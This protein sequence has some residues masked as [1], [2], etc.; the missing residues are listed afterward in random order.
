MNRNKIFRTLTAAL[1]LALLVLA[2]PAT[3]A[4]AQAI[5]CSP[6]SGTVGTTVAIS[7]QNL[8]YIGA[9]ATVFIFFN[10][11]YAGSGTITSGTA[12]P[13][14]N[15]VISGSFAVPATATAGVAI[16]TVWSLPA[17]GGVGNTQLGL[18]SFTV[19]VAGITISPVQG[20]VGDTVIISGTGF[21]P[22]TVVTI[23]FDAV[24][25]T[26]SPASVT[27]TTVGSFTNVTF[28][29][30]A[31]VRGSHIVRAQDAALNSATATFTTLPKVTLTPAT[32]GVG[33]TPL[34]SGTGFAAGSAVTF[35]MDDVLI[36]GATATT[37]TTGSFTNTPVTIPAGYRG[38]HPLKAQDAS[39]NVAIATFTI[40]QKITITPTTGSAG[41]TVTVAGTGFD[42]SKGITITYGGTSVTTTPAAVNTGATGSFSGVTFNVPAGV[43]TTYSVV[44]SDGIYSASA[45]FVATASA[46]ISQ[47]T[48]ATSPG[49]VGM[50]LVISGTGFKASPATVT[51]T[52]A[53]DPVTLATV[54][55]DANGSFSATVTI[56]ASEGGQHT[57]TVSDGTT[58][59][60]FTFFMEE[61][62][63]PV[64][65]PLLPLMDSKAKQPVTFDWQDVTDD[66]LPVTYTL[67]IARDTA[68]TDIVLEKPGLTTSGYTLTE[69]EKLE[70]VSKDEPYLW[71]VK[72]I[73]AASNESAWTG[74]GSFYVGFTLP[75]LSDLPDWAMYTIYGV[76]GLLL[77]LIGFWVGRR[78]MAY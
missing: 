29:V 53:T 46:T 16:I 57:I 44:A 3:P 77:F 43:A 47:T 2:V 37:G 51:I 49:H 1:I 66:S 70:S 11:N 6:T 69:A 35:Y 42:A 7:G 61:V 72:A 10:T 50:S 31:S 12:T 14:A 5:T 75:W 27:T 8:S 21:T 34:A 4:M 58:P 59:K 65:Q 48:S 64:P 13:P 71:R 55:T 32:G 54:P 38:D 68:F 60:Q 52:Y 26:T 41:T 63:P 40:T 56:P 20:Y 24:A 45:S 23:T 39:L 36:T 18:G 22:S 15:G 67:Q 9:A 78:T 73:D 17:Y 25:V 74:T 62:A 33:D 76:G 28:T 19:I 30:P